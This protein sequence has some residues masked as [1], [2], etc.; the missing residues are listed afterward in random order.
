M[1]E[2]NEWVSEWLN[3]L[4]IMHR[5]H[6]HTHAH[7]QHNSTDQPTASPSACRPHSQ[8]Y[9]KT[10][11]ILQW[12]HRRSLYLNRRVRA[13]AAWLP[14]SMVDWVTVSCLSHCPCNECFI[15]S[16]LSLLYLD[17]HFHY[18]ACCCRRPKGWVAAGEEWQVC[19]AFNRIAGKVVG[20]R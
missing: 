6:K 20:L 7:L 18:K 15:V 10:F 12:H 8:L 19:N 14:G 1:N 11:A 13:L 2:M 16:L 9:A 5:A 17:F 4:V 3:A